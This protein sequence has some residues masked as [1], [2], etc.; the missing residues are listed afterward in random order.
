[1]EGDSPNTERTIE[2]YVRGIVNMDIGD[3]SIANILLDRNLKA[4]DPASGLDTKTKMLLK[5]DVYM[6]CAN[7]PSVRSSVEDADGNWRHKESGGQITDENKRFWKEQAISIYKMYGEF[8]NTSA[9][10]RIH[11]R[12]M[13]I[14]RNGNGC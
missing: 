8:H 12:G 6:V 4:D 5:A 13:R 10:P 14:W 7:M 11:A 1:M 9:G 3:E 2:Q